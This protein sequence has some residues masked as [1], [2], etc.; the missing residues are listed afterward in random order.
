MPL[1]A[2]GTGLPQLETLQ[3][4]PPSEPEFKLGTGTLRQAI[5][6]SRAVGSSAACL[7]CPRASLGSPRGRRALPE[8]IESGPS[9]SPAQGPPTSLA[10]SMQRVRK[11]Q[12]TS[13]PGQLRARGY[14]GRGTVRQHA[15]PGGGPSLTGPRGFAFRPEDM[16]EAPLVHTAQG[17][18]NWFIHHRQ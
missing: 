13:C 16:T 18:Y 8:T 4:Q 15:A 3:T 14:N 12:P 9:S 1:E 11:E 10:T 2:P 5:R 17:M 6:L 7:S